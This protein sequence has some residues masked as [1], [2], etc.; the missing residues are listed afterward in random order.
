MDEHCILAYSFFFQN[1]P[2][3][4]YVTTCFCVLDS[5]YWRHVC[6]LSMLLRQD[7]R[8]AKR[9]LAFIYKLNPVIHRK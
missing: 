4:A 5:F 3:D 9:R 2:K 7:P 8:K 6:F 1:S